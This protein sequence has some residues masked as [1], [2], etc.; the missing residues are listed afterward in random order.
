MARD[1]LPPDVIRVLS[2]HGP[3]EV[4]VGEDTGRGRAATAPFEDVVHLFVRRG[5]P[6]EAALLQSVEVDVQARAPDGAYALRMTGRAH[7][8]QPLGRHPQRSALEPWLPEGA[9]PA[10]LLVAPFVAE[11]VEFTRVEGAGEGRY[12]G[13]T[14]AGR[15]RPG[16]WMT[17]ARATFGGLAAPAAASAVL[18]PWGWLILQGEDYPNRPGALALAAVG[19]LGIL[20]A[21]R[22]LTLSLAFR[23]WRAGRARTSDA[24]VLTEALLAPVPATRLGLGLLLLGVAAIGTLSAAWEPAAAWVALL[25]NGAWL[26]GPAWV[27]HLLA[28]RPDPRS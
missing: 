15:E 13:P 16:R 27:L 19:G 4:F 10:T 25:G 6:L 1:N 14:P 8:G 7:A 22:L 3:V 11:R 12:H 21:T 23:Q 28:A 2:F 20:G 9:S 5:S 24:P 26:L 17:L 18:V